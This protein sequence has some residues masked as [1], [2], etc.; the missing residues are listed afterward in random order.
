MPNPNY[1]ELRLI[2]NYGL[3][4]TA[5]LSDGQPTR[6]EVAV[7][8]DS[9]EIDKKYVYAAPLGGVLVELAHYASVKQVVIQCMATSSGATG[10]IFYV[11]N[12]TGALVPEAIGVGEHVSFCDPDVTNGILLYSRAVAELMD[13]H[14]IIVGRKD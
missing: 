2:A 11:D 9:D 14:I 5:T 12:T 6:V 8:S 4:P 3:D 10:D 13:Y 1:S 7:S